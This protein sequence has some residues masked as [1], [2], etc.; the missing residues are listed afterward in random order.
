M[1]N[2]KF[3]HNRFNFEG[4]CKKQKLEKDKDSEQKF[5]CGKATRRQPYLVGEGHNKGCCGTKV[6]NA[7]LMECCEDGV[8]RSQVTPRGHFQSN[9]LFLTIW[10]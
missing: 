5:C 8:A 10:K 9:L 3:G 1:I 7:G 6:Y 4:N 2:T